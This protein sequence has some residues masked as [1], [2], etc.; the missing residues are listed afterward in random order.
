MNV[1][2]LNER[3]T[4]QKNE[5]VTDRI[6]NHTNAWTDYYTCTATIS[7]E[8]GREEEDT[9]QTASTRSE[10]GSSTSINLAKPYVF[11]CFIRRTR[12]LSPGRAP[13]TK[14]A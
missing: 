7:G 3:V 6:G 4:F 14:R 2:M 11:F 13:F 5:V 9:G 1:A 12:T 8:N 10:D